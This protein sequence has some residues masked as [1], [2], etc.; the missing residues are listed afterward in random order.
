MYIKCYNI[1]IT[2]IPKFSLPFCYHAT[3]FSSSKFSHTNVILV[4]M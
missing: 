3:Y 4:F 1:N 2:L